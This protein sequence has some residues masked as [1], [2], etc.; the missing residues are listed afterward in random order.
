[1]GKVVGATEIKFILAT[2]KEHKVGT[3]FVVSKE[4]M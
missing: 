1:M 3:G 4:L 2:K